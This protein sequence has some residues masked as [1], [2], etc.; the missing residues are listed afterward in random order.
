MPRHPPAPHYSQLDARTPPHTIVYTTWPGYGTNTT[1]T[2]LPGY[3]FNTYNTETPAH[4]PSP[5]RPEYISSR[6]ETQQWQKSQR[7]RTS[8]CLDKGIRF[9]RFYESL[10]VPDEF[11]NVFLTRNPRLGLLEQRMAAIE[12]HFTL[13]P[14]KLYNSGVREYEKVMYPPGIAFQ[15]PLPLTLNSLRSLTSRFTGSFSQTAS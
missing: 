14:T 1:S 15:H 12:L 9:S 2:L 7:F 6:T 3:K 10:V 5:T 13:L 11:A 8:L 4:G